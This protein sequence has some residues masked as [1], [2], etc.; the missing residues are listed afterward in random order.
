MNR[1]LSLE[2]RP[3]VRVTNGGY[4]IQDFETL[5]GVLKVKTTRTGC[6]F[7]LG[8]NIYTMYMDGK[9]IMNTTDYHAILEKIAHHLGLC[10]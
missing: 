3:Y 2:L 10:A 6:G 7:S 9:Q 5:D 1:N 4:L 8:K